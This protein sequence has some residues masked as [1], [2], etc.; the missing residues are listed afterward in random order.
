M[1]LAGHSVNRVGERLR[2]G[3]GLRAQHHE[4]MLR[5]R[6][7][8]GW[9]EVHSENY[10]G[11]GGAAGK[12][13]RQIRTHYPLSLHGVGLSIGSTDPL[14][15]RHLGELKQL[16]RELE[17]VFVSEHLS[18]GSAG[19]RFTNDLLPL[20]YS[21]DALQHMVDRVSQVQEALGRQIL[22]ENVSSYL[23][24]TCSVMPEWEFLAAVSARSGCYILLDVNNLYVNS[25][26][27]GFDPYAYLKQLPPQA[28][29]EMH[30]A[31]HSV[32]R[33]GERE[34]RIDTHSTHVCEPVWELYRAAVQRFGPVPT[35][36]EWDTNIPALDVLL[37]EASKADRVAEESNA[38]AA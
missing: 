6:P 1:L 33:A 5:R 17:P 2:A 37:D 3:I 31:G 4:E 7:A 21:D 18:W 12:Y 20:P 28:V 19:G 11:L 15:P 22:I 8:V 25:M 32:N 13:L 35:L 23:Q 16:V 29:L 26:N 10:F 34:I 30:L 14:D 9:L 24:F 27:H 38:L 36:I